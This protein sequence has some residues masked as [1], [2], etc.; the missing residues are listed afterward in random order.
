MANH[1]RRSS[2]IEL[3][4]KVLTADSV[5]VDA[6][7]IDAQVRKLTEP[8]LDPRLQNYPNKFVAMTVDLD[9]GE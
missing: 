6:S 4:T 5:S 2:A 3:E 1:Q 9:D 7:E 8:Y